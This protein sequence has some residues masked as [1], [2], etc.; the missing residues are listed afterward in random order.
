MSPII[1][2]GINFLSGA[3]RALSA[4]VERVKK[5]EVAEGLKTAGQVAVGVGI[6]YGAYRGIKS[7]LN[8]YFN[9]SSQVRDLKEQVRK[10]QEGIVALQ[11]GQGQVLSNQGSHTE[12]LNTIQEG[13]GRVIVVLEEHTQVLEDQTT[14]LRSIDQA[15]GAQS[16]Q[17]RQIQEAQGEQNRQLTQIAFVGARI[18]HSLEESR[19]EQRETKMLMAGTIRELLARLRMRS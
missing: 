11:T 18:L 12:A 5:L 3:G 10:A 7:G 2:T 14:T 6:C 16:S 13:Q 17:L 4:G 1:E 19:R 15:Q 8:W 9:L